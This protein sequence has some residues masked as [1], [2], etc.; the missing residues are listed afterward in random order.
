MGGRI[1]LLTM[2]YTKVYPYFI[3][4]LSK[5]I[6]FPVDIPIMGNTGNRKIEAKG[7]YVTKQGYTPYPLPYPGIM[8]KISRI[9][10]I[11]IV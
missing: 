7:K 9:V 11:A 4:S 1:T 10:R 3:D 2:K 6:S 8:N 5:C